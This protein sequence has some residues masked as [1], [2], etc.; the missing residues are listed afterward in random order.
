MIRLFSTDSTTP[1]TW[2]S[3]IRATLTYIAISWTVR[4]IWILAEAQMKK[5]ASLTTL[6]VIVRHGE[7][8]DIDVDFSSDSQPAIVYFLDRMGNSLQRLADRRAFEAD[9][10]RADRS[11]PEQ[12]SRRAPISDTHLRSVVDALAHLT[13]A[14][15][16]MVKL[17]Q[18]TL[19]I[20]KPPSTEPMPDRRVGATVTATD[21]PSAPAPVPDLMTAPIPEG[22]GHGDLIAAP[23][24]GFVDPTLASIAPAPERE[25]WVERERWQG[26]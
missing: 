7:D 12:P 5:S 6:K 17:Q 18:E 11:G 14:V 10:A 20:L 24:G 22:A 23:G 13:S 26:A 25:S 3:L 15:Q 16:S 8:E 19:A 1:Q 2:R 9:R 4:A 21:G